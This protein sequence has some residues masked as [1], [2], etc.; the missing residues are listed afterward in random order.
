MSQKIFKYD[1]FISYRH[2]E[3]D[4][5]VAELLHKQL[6]SFKV[7]KIANKEIKETGKQGIKRVFRDKDELPLAGNLSAPI[8]EALKESE[9][10]IVI[11]SPRTIESMWVQKEIETFL[12]YRDASHILA[13]LIEGE[14]QEAFPPQIC[15]MKKEVIGKDGT[16]SYEEIPVEP[17]AADVRGETK[18]EI[19]AKLKQEMLRIAAPMLGCEYDDLKNRHRE[20]RIKRLLATFATAGTIC[21][22]FGAFS[23]YQAIR[24]KNQADQIQQQAEALQEENEKNLI[25]QSKSLSDKAVELYNK[26]DRKGALLVALAGIPEDLEY[27]DRPIVAES[28]AALA[29]ILQVYENETVYQ[30]Y[31]ML[32]HD[33]ITETSCL[34]E[35]ATILVTLDQLGQLYSWNVDT[36]ELLAKTEDSVG[37]IKESSI[38]FVDK[39]TF[40]CAGSEGV[41]CINA[42]DLTSKW[43][44]TDESGYNVVLTQDKKMAAVS[45]TGLISIYDVKTGKLISTYENSQY[46]E[47]GNAMNFSPNGQYLAVSL[48]DY[49]DQGQG[50]GALLETNSGE[51]INSYETEYLTWDQV[52]PTDNG[53]C[54]VLSYNSNEIGE[55]GSTVN[56]KITCFEKSGAV[57]FEFGGM[58]SIFADMKFFGEDI[59]YPDA[60][61]LNII[62]SVDGSVIRQIYYSDSIRNYQLLQD[63]SVIVAGLSDGSVYASVLG[64]NEELT[65]Q[66]LDSKDYGIRRI[67]QYKNKIVEEASASSDVYVYKNA[68]GSKADVIEEMQSSVLEIE[69][70]NN[71]QLLVYDGNRVGAYNIADKKLLYQVET[72]EYARKMVL[73]EPEKQFCLIKSNSVSVYG[74]EDGKLLKEIPIEGNG[75]YDKERKVFV[76][77]ARGKMI[78]YDM[79]TLKQ[80]STYEIADLSEGYLSDDKSLIVGMDIQK[81]GFYYNVETKEKTELNWQAKSIVVNNQ[82]TEYLIADANQKQISLYEFG[83]KSP[84]AFIEVKID[85]V[86]AIG[87]SPGG[88]YVFVS[89]KDDSVSIYDAFDL[90]LVKTLENISAV[91]T[92]ET[93]E[94]KNME[95]LYD[96]NGHSVGYLFDKDMDLLYEIPSFKKIAS[97][98]NHI[99]S[100]S[101]TFVL[102]FPVYDLQM[103]VEEAKQLL[104][105]RKLTAE[106]KERYYV[107]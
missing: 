39:D 88:E 40:I 72:E 42:K 50:K 22:I 56:Q 81:M 104:N 54:F 23:T 17:L 73:M 18:K 10:L 63:N 62:S 46:N 78:L 98:G 52:L 64:E 85:F 70:T 68:L 105:G 67:Y 69:A 4:S 20:R 32:S 100:S 86:D 89:S 55:Y 38:L 95:L 28:T 66:Y 87:F 24:I 82:K 12:E 94:A 80:L 102:E 44:V 11:C 2:A 29:K 8:T 96:E 3:L 101:R 77:N 53:E 60:S 79:T 51:V 61:T 21:L 37:I 99:Y 107:R 27:P 6:E 41:A 58:M 13:V 30:P 36:G 93:V 76:D 9:F 49:F 90:S 59:I 65:R 74:L 16:I 5:F 106:E 14:P 103:L 71:G 45:G 48:T 43:A 7:P 47:M 34:N 26:G 84:R 91:D 75:Y 15:T 57:R 92:W 33:T 31:F 1:A 83:E 19:K 25:L 35:D 97:D